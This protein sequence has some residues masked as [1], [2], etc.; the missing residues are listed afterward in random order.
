MDLSIFSQVASSISRTFSPTRFQWHRQKEIL[1]DDP[2]PFPGKA[3]SRKA[4]SLEPALSEV[5][6]SARH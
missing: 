1:R 2:G 4:R 3:L 5:E 6:G